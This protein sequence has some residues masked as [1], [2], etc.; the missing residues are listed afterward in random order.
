MPNLLHINFRKENLTKPKQGEIMK[1]EIKKIISLGM[2]YSGYISADGKDI[3]ICFNECT[4][5]H[6]LMKDHILKVNTGNFDDVDNYMKFY[7]SF[8]PTDG[9][10]K[11]TKALWMYPETRG[12][13]TSYKDLSSDKN[14]SLKAY[15]RSSIENNLRLLNECL[16]Y[17]NPVVNVDEVIIWNGSEI[18]NIPIS[19]FE[20][21]FNGR[22]VRYRDNPV[23]QEV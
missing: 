9:L 22:E 21:Y 2:N 23:C 7:I 19:N 15:I 18:R 20:H 14:K 5:P 11:M 4:Y 10:M 16:I 12:G 8:S 1:T 13:F 3:C 17:E 6:L